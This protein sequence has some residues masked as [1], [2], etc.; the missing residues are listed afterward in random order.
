MEPFPTISELDAEY[1]SWPESGN[2]FAHEETAFS[3]KKAPATTIGY[4]N[5]NSSDPAK[6]PSLRLL[7]TLTASRPFS[8]LV[9]DIIKSDDKLFFISYSPPNQTR[10]EWKLVQ[11]DFPSTMK[12]HPSC[13]QDGKFLVQF[14]IQHFN[15][16]SVNLT[17]QRFWL[18]Y[19]STSNAKTLGSQ[20][21]LIPPTSVSSE[22]AKARN[23]VPYREW[24][25]L[26]HAENLLHGPFD[27]ATLN[28]R[29]TRDRLSDTE[30][31]LLISAKDRYDCPPP[32]FRHSI[33]HIVTT[34]QPITQHFDLAVNKRIEAFLFKLHFTDETLSS[35]GV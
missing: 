10:R 8:Q 11:I 4:T 24:I 1:D 22:I 3:G 26:S 2:P 23:L 35:Y 33:V 30:W 20:Y 7:S 12:L 9:A 25:Y 16:N 32:A 34:E 21:H 31:Q 14:Y 5:M 29:Q 28:N 27:F 18:E 15:D 13:L 6:L 19:H 17:D